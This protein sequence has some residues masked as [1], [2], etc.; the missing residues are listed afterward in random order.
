MSSRQYI[1]E[2]WNKFRETVLPADVGPVQLI[3]TRRAFFAGAISCFA[4]VIAVN[5][6][7]PDEEGI[8]RFDD[9]ALEFKM[10]AERMRSGVL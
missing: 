5:E 9:L 10:Y 7:T 2:E 6:N 8:K 1:M 4:S 3:E